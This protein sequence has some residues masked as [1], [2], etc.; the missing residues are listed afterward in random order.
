MSELL[1]AADDKAVPI[2]FVTKENS[3]SVLKGLP[4]AQQNWIA[5]NG[6]EAKAGHHLVLPGAGDALGGVVFGLEAESARHRDVFLPAKLVTVLPAGTY[7]FVNSSHDDRLATLGWLL[8]LYRFNRYRSNDIKALRLIAPDGIVRDEIAGIAESVSFARDLINTPANDLGPGELALAARKLAEKHK[9]AFKVIVGDDLL[10]ENFPMIHA[11]GRASSRAPRLIDFSWGD[12]AH[13]K[14]TLV[15]KG[16]IFDTGG[17]DIK[18]GASMLLMKKD[19]GGAA[20]VLACAS[21]IMAAGLRIRLRVLI[22]AVENSIS[23]NAFR[24]S[25]I[26]AS[27]KGLSVEIGN[28]DAEGRLVLGDALALADEEAPELIVDMATLTGA[29]RVAL[30]PDLPPLFSRD[31]AVANALL[32]HAAE[33]GDPLWRL[34][35]WPPYDSM[36]ESKAADI[37][38]APG[39]G[40]AGAITAAL[41]LNRFVEKAAAYVHLDIYAWN[42]STKPGRPEGG[43]VMGARALY[44]YLKKKYG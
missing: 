19:M 18:P 29:A 34:P 14:V 25:D 35:L 16:V 1:L 32:A 37:N 27:R 11:V 28:T 4:Q 3:A 22:P 5:A 41:F 8:G 10:K 38:N 36:L 17:L 7:R 39:G 43:E 40:L 15:G 30:G 12:P 9:A 23:A 26:L 33:E 31:D 20:S 13:P 2:W 21:M 44:G 42:P 24:P 6:F